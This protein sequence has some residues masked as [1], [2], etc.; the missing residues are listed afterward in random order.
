MK[1]PNL[2][3]KN[4][5]LW[6]SILA[7]IMFLGGCSRFG[8]VLGPQSSNNTEAAS[9]TFEPVIY[10][11]P[12]AAAYPPEGYQF[13]NFHNKSA[14]RLDDDDYDDDYDI[15]WEFTEAGQDYDGVAKHINFRDGD[16]IRW[17]GSSAVFPAGALP[18]K[19]HWISMVRTD[20]PEPW[21]DYGPHGTRFDKLVTLRISYEDCDLPEGVEPEDLKLFY[22]NEI[23]G[24]YE[25]I[26]EY[27]NLEEE[28]LEG[29]TDHFSRY[30]IA[31]SG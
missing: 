1:R 21:I 13:I 20:P 17:D 30:I 9:G 29:Q 28:Y 11:Y 14:A 2:N 25:L 18:C 8:D 26:S 24:E 31:A 3:L 10:D 16:A 6:I 7:L 5:T 15:E 22:W 12:E 19:K 23:T 27:N 4:L